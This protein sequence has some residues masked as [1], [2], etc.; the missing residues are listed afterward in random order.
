MLRVTEPDARRLRAVVAALAADSFT[1]RRVGSDGG[2]AAARFLAGE[3]REIGA[4]VEFQEF[5]VD[6]VRELY[7]VPTLTWIADGRRRELKFRKDFCEH[8]ASAD[9]SSLVTGPVTPEGA[10][11]GAWAL[12]ESFSSDAIA[13]AHARGAIGILVP[14]GT[15]GAGWMPKMIAGPRRV[16]LPA[17]ALRRELHEQLHTHGDG[18][19][20]E[21]AAT[22]PLRTVGA[23][24]QNVIGTF[25]RAAQGAPAVLLT[26]HY[27]GVGDDPDGTRYPAACDNASGV[28]SVVEAAR[29]LHATLPQR[30]GLQ[31]ALLD[32]EEV[33]AHGSAAHAGTVASGTQV[34]N[35]DGAAALSVAHVEAGGDAQTLLH[36]LDRAARDIGVPLAARAMPS[37]NRRYAAAGLAVVGIGMGM[38]GYQT[39]LET[40]DQVDSQTLSDAS[41]LLVHTATRV[42]STRAAP[43]SGDGA[44]GLASNASRSAE[45]PSAVG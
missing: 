3:I 6:D 35:L 7:S 28:A 38:P 11:P 27:D 36:C 4:V 22:V 9:R 5:R 41:R 29:I 44:V 43:A 37:D 14:R 8:L 17:L 15:D 1:G 42:T 23:I 2:R 30:V 34:L 25:R 18:G 10:R 45:G 31:V 13:D 12:H 21:I 20:T 33:G 32:G 19:T 39:P 16:A 40:P 24:G 26:A